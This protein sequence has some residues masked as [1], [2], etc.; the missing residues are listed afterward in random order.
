MASSKTISL[1]SSPAHPPTWNP[2]STVFASVSAF[3][4][5]LPRFFRTPHRCQHVSQHCVGSYRIW[6]ERDGLLRL[7]ERLGKLLGVQ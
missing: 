4:V 2:G 5:G 6:G 1:P 3:W 7:E